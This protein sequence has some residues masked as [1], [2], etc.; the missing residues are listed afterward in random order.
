VIGFAGLSHLG[1][2]SSAAA[3]AKGFDVVAYDADASLCAALAAG[4]PPI[5]EPGLT[6]LLRDVSSQIRY[7]ANASDLA[8]CEL[9]YIS[10]DVP[11]DTA[12]RSDLR[13]VRELLGEAAHV[14]SAG[15]TL[16][17][18][19]QVHPGFSR[20]AKASIEPIGQKGLHLY[21]QV[22]TLV[23]GNAVDRAL[24]P[25][26]FIVGCDDHSRPLA[27]PLETLLM[28]FGCPILPMR[29]ESAELAKIAINHFLAA[30][31]AMTNTLAELC[32]AV[33]ADWAEIAP[34]LRLD[35]RIGPNAYLTPGLG[36]AGGNI[37]RD[38]ATVRSL[39]AR[40]G[41]DASVVDAIVRNSDHR[42]KWAIREVRRALDGRISDTS[43]VAVWGLAYKHDTASTKNSPALALIEALAPLP[44]RAYDPQARVNG[45]YRHLSVVNAALDACVDADVLAIMTSWPEFASVDLTEIA[46]AMRGRVIVDPFAIL[47]R[48]RCLAAGFSYSR[49]GSARDA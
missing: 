19:S 37:E 36:L 43:S 46:R 33:S 44:M 6:A 10:V 22:E 32:E 49:L 16:V 5:A 7:T 4:N 42:G 45:A 17:I 31:V 18:L 26:R 23:F 38:L 28:A 9:I 21:Y 12:N 39:A 13:P 41:T 34:A 30:S 29:Y 11:T 8:Q 2:V 15:A 27:E 40:S 24:H 47:D 35:R 3:A 48:A 14:A 25:E 20:E 1:I